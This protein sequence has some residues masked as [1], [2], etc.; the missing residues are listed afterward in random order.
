MAWVLLNENNVVIRKQLDQEDG[1]I[2][3]S[4]AVVCGQIKQLDGTFIN[5]TQTSDDLLYDLREQRNELLQQTDYWAL[6]DHTMT[7]EQIA[8]RQALRDITNNYT[9][10]AD[11]VWPTKP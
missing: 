4:N 8:Y 10:L 5:P 2:E 11:V 1:L 7:A 6:N 3:V 9:S